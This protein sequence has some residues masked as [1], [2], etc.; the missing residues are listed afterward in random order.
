MRAV[1]ADRHVPRLVDRVVSTVVGVVVPIFALIIHI[2]FEAP[3]ALATWIGIVEDLDPGDRDS[4]VRARAQRAIETGSEATSFGIDALHGVT[5]VRREDRFARG[6][7]VGRCGFGHIDRCNRP[8]VHYC[9]R[10]G[11]CNAA[12]FEHLI[13]RCIEGG[14]VASG[15]ALHQPALL[16]CRDTAGGAFETILVASRRRARLAAGDVHCHRLCERELVLQPLIGRVCF[17]ELLLV[18]SATISGA[19]SGSASRRLSAC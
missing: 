15:R 8:F 5:D 10:I 19:S 14:V 16:V 2:Q 12:R 3:L 13:E 1:A 18:R 6:G 11:R 17:D 7:R 9:R 4:Q